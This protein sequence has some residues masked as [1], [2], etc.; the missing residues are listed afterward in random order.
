MYFCLAYVL[1]YYFLRCI[2]TKNNIK[3]I[4]REQ[5][6]YFRTKTDN[7]DVFIN[8]YMFSN[9]IPEKNIN[10]EFKKHVLLDEFNYFRLHA[11]CH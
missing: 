4:Y 5:S 2:H 3:I 6:I 9:V 8:L 11:V 1:L 7:L 10:N